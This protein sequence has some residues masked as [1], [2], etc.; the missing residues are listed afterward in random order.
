MAIHSAKSG[1]T[2]PSPPV[3]NIKNIPAPIGGMDNRIPLSSNNE[4]ICTY[5]FNL[6]PSSFGMKIRSGYREW[7]VGLNNG[8]GSGLGTIIPFEGNSEGAFDDKLFA[9]TNE[10]IWDVSIVGDTP[11]LKVAFDNTSIEAGFGTYAHYIDGSDDEFLYY[12]DSVNGLFQYIQDTD[13]WE[14]PTGISGIDI[15]LI[16]FVVVHKLRMWF[17]VQNSTIASYLPVE[18]NSGNIEG[19]FN[20]GAKFKHGGGLVGLFN[21]TVDGG[22]G[23]DDF[24][25]GISSAGDVLPYKGSDPSQSDWGLVGTYFVG[26]MAKGSR[27]ASQYGGNVILLSTYGITQMS[28]LLRGVDPRLPNED[29]IGSKIAE[30]IRTDMVQYRNEDGWDIKYLAT[31]GIIIIV[32]PK[33]LDGTY[34]QYVYQGD[35][36]GW[37]LWRG[38]AITTIDVW[39]DKVYFGTEDGRVMAMDVSKD[40]IL[41]D[42]PPNTI[43]GQN[44]QFSM[45]TSYQDYGTPGIFK[46]GKIIRPNFISRSDVAFNVQ[47]RYDYDVSEL[48][49][50]AISPDK[51]FSQWDVSKWDAAIW[52][53]NSLSLFGRTVGASGVGRYMAIAIRGSGITGTRLISMDAFWDIGGGL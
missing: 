36:S 24:L 6:I 21:W 14:V 15:S 42:P 30:F 52:S 49:L 48:E 33:R 20:F 53:D 10:G 8:S 41:L 17:S 11:V 40:G 13:T 44:I 4:K 1:L 16:N 23:V 27:C 29:S 25:I 46:R 18:S 35:I 2:R 5:T 31:E 51:P 3:T 19:T 37:G 45:L 39:E 34:L 28:D 26:S 12:A 7:Q 38:L 32:T 50:S 22:D 47:F 43:N 9:A